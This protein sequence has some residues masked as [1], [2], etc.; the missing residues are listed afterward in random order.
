MAY[1]AAHEENVQAGVSDRPGAGRRPGKA[2]ERPKNADADGP[3]GN[4]PEKPEKAKAGPLEAGGGGLPSGWV[5]VEDYAR[6]AGVTRRLAVRRCY[7]GRVACAKIGGRWAVSEAEAVI[8]RKPKPKP[9]SRSKRIDES[10]LEG[11]SKLDVR[12]ALASGAEIGGR[13]DR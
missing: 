8:A 4:G 10:A 6:A 13:N 2:P 9:G 3:Q 1:A 5:E 7:E 12:K 11:M